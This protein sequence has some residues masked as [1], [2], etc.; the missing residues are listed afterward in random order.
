MEKYSTLSS[1]DS[2]RWQGVIVYVIFATCHFCAFSKSLIVNCMVSNSVY[3]D[4][5]RKSGWFCDLCYHIDYND[6]SRWYAA[7]LRH[8]H[9]STEQSIRFHDLLITSAFPGTLVIHPI[10]VMHDAVFFI[11]FVS[12]RSSFCFLWASGAM[13]CS[14]WA[15]GAMFCFI[16]VSGA[17]FCFLYSSDAVF[18]HLCASNAV[19]CYMCESDAAFRYLCASDAVFCFLWA[20]DALFCYICKSDVVFCFLWSS[21]AVFCFLWASDALF[22]VLSVSTVRCCVRFMW[23]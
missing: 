2:R 23:Y 13:F 16:C 11:L 10:S 19:F 3:G 22:C 17:V 15:S 9:L 18:C 20:L 8:S 7:W 6:I 12:F 4:S 1:C 5:W 21:D 14:L